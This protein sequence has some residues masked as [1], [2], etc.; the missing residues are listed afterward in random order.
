MFT[1]C[2]HYVYQSSYYN[3]SVLRSSD[4]NLNNKFYVRVSKNATWCSQ[5]SNSIHL[6]MIHASLGVGGGFS[7]NI[8][9]V[10]F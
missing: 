2:S 7:N 4:A 9:E 5:S 3:I 10:Q 6:E 1:I 8:Y